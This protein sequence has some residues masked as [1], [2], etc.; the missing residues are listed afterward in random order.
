MNDMDEQNTGASNE[1]ASIE[2][3]RD[4]LKKAG[5]FAAV[6]PPAVVMMLSVSDKANARF[7][8]SCTPPPGGTPC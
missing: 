7:T 2:N 4:F 5:R 1:D 3:R 6:T 8:S